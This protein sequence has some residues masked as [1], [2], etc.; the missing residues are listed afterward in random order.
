M[1][2]TNSTS[3]I[4]M[5]SLQYD[6][7]S[8]KPH[9][10]KITT[11]F[12]TTE[13][14]NRTNEYT[15]HHNPY[16][17][18][19]TKHINHSKTVHCANPM[20]HDQYVQPTKWNPS[21]HSFWSRAHSIIL[22]TI[23]LQLKNHIVMIRIVPESKHS[24]SMHPSPYGNTTV[25]LAFQNVRISNHPREILTFPSSKHADSTTQTTSSY[26]STIFLDASVPNDRNWKNAKIRHGNT[27]M[28]VT[29]KKHPYHKI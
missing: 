13:Q 2:Y 29:K 15:T 20:Q 9:S 14:I 25:R 28:T 11:P 4:R 7:I 27:P 3:S 6:N 22:T 24:S 12:V 18:C 1:V 17:Y 26:Q 16:E 8:F 10:Q 5:Q 23:R 21:L 19:H